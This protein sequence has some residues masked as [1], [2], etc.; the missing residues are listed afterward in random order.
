MTRNLFKLLMI[1]L[2]LGSVCSAA[3]SQETLQTSLKANHLLQARSST[4]QDPTAYDQHARFSPAVITDKSG[5]T[6]EQSSLDQKL[7]KFTLYLVIIGFLQ[8]IVFIGQL[9]VFG[10]QALRLRQTV[11]AAG[12]Q[13]L[14]MQ[15]SIE[16]STR[17]ATAMERLADASTTSSRAATDSV[18]MLR[19][20]T[21]AQSRAYLTVVIGGGTYQ[22]RANNLRFEVKPLVVN[23]GQT[24][25]HNV[26]YQAVCQVLPHPLDNGFGFPMRNI[27]HGNGVLGPQQNF[28][29]SAIIEGPY[30]P[31]DDVP[32]IMR[33][34]DGRRLYIWGEVTYED[35]YRLPHRTRFCHTIHWLPDRRNPG[36]YVVAG[37]YSDNHN[38][39][40]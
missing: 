22:D 37:Y 34:S 19:E 18:A 4:N 8:L 14:D 11:E 39:A 28:I 1:T 20:R 7:V 35:V 27:W 31:D 2:L 17:A 24:P 26:R 5:I 36:E 23:T 40:D 6:S 13:S 30:F 15:H 16:I 21:A 33:G 12:Q 10:K 25:A 32:V 3:Q 29:L 38:D 9:I